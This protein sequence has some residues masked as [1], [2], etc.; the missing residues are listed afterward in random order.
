MHRYNEYIKINE[1]DRSQWCSKNF[2]NYRSMLSAVNIRHQLMDLMISLNIP[3]KS[4]P[5][6]DEALHNNNIRR[7]LCK[8]FFMQ[9]AHREKGGY[10]TVKDHQ[11]SGLCFSWFVE[12]L[13]PP[14]DDHAI[15]GGLGHLQWVRVHYLSLYPNDFTNWSQVVF[16]QNNCFHLIGSLKTL[17]SIMILQTIPILKRKASSSSCMKRSSDTS[18]WNLMIHL[19]CLRVNLYEYT[20][21]ITISCSFLSNSSFYGIYSFF[22]RESQFSYSL[23]HKLLISQPFSILLL[24]FRLLLLPSKNPPKISLLIHFQFFLNDFIP[25]FS[26]FIPF[27]Y[28]SDYYNGN[29][30]RQETQWERHSPCSRFSPCCWLWSLQVFGLPALGPSSSEDMVIEPHG[31]GI[32][33]TGLSIMCPVNTYARIGI[34]LVSCLTIIAPRSGLAAKKFIDVGAGVVD[35]DYRYDL[36]RCL[37][38]LRG[39]VGVV[40]FNHGNEPFESIPLIRSAIRSQEGRSHCPVDSRENLHGEHWRGRHSAWDREVCLFPWLKYQY[41]GAGGFGSTGVE[42]VEMIHKKP[43]HD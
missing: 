3:M 19:F 17:R 15:R 34:F 29:P 30:L 12:C 43:R 5:V 9:V 35:A 4:S 23:P 24:F 21:H 10:L 41:R 22:L 42:G 20:N 1:S 8:G 38:M 18:K 11:V 27:F 14:F 31:K 33:P 7:C 6:K 40:L 39:P 2:I 36:S 26:Y 13:L 37:F 28:P 25:S 32:V 16:F